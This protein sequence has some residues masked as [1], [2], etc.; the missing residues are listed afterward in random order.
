MLKLH[1]IIII[2]NV[3]DY[4][5]IKNFYCQQFNLFDKSTYFTFI[6]FALQKSA[7]NALNNH[8][9]IILILQ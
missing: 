4:F 8:V 5:S 9:C 7:T 2:N 3:S 6:L 1:F